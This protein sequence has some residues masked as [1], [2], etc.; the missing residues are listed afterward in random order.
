MTTVARAFGMWPADVVVKPFH[1]TLMAYVGLMERERVERLADHMQRVRDA[2]R[3]NAAFANPKAL[4]EEHSRALSALRR[5]P[6]DAPAM[7]VAEARAY[8]EALLARVAG[9]T[10]VPVS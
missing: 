1:E 2:F 8:A 7:T 4:D 5:L 6:T 10:F 9:Q 3:T